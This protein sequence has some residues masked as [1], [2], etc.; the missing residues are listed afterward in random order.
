MLNGT[1]VREMLNNSFSES[2]KNVG[3]LRKLGK[4]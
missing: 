1:L 3:Y 2:K 4:L